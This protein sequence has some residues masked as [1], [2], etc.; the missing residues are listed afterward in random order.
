VKREVLEHVKRK[1]KA[2]LVE[3]ENDLMAVIL[4]MEDDA[5]HQD[6]ANTP[7]TAYHQEPI[8]CVEGEAGG[9]TNERIHYQDTANTANTE[10]GDGTNGGNNDGDDTPTSPDTWERGLGDRDAG[11][12]GGSGD[13]VYKEE[14]GASCVTSS[15]ASSV[16]VLAC[17]PDGTRESAPMA[18][19]SAPMELRKEGQRPL[20]AAAPVAHA[21]AQEGAG[22]VVPALEEEAGCIHTHTHTDCCSPLSCS[23]GEGRDGDVWDE[24]G[25]VVPVA[26]EA[27]L[28]AVVEAPD[29]PWTAAVSAA[30]A[31]AHDEDA[32]AW[33]VAMEAAL[34]V[35][36]ARAVSASKN[37][38]N[39][40]LRRWEADV[41]HEHGTAAHE[42]GTVSAPKSAIFRS[43][44]TDTGVASSAQQVLSRNVLPI[45]PVVVL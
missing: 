19:D 36:T 6:T 34:E 41:A 17:K 18:R 11:G 40:L 32:E 16:T 7:N 4:A 28:N 31:A 39:A 5:Y 37:S 1:A 33:H 23:S 20:R 24:D 3:L 25:V 15:V 26:L 2:D 42:H 8:D 44:P 38:K 30:M 9:S 13:A 10:P 21:H 14:G 12:I 27:A 45:P 35:A 29:A 43:P 22:S